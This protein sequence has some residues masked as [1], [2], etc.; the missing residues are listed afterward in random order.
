MTLK[1][2]K[3]SGGFCSFFCTSNYQEKYDTL[4]H[5]RVMRA[6]NLAMDDK[7]KNTHKIKMA[8]RE[9]VEMKGKENTKNYLTVLGN[10]MDDDTL[11]FLHAEVLEIRRCKSA[12]IE[13]LF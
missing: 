6:I 5:K 12:F 10:R 9:A 7:L 11:N 1:L 4:F 8:L 3:P 13:A 2:A